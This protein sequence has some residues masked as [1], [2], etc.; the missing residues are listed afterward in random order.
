MNELQNF[1]EL[2]QCRLCDDDDYRGLGLSLNLLC[3]S[4]VPWQGIVCHSDQ[5]FG[6]P[7]AIPYYGTTP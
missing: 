5:P 1:N 4:T 3:G 6:D 7:M 2:S